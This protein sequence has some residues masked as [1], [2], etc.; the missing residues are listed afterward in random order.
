[1]PVSAKRPQADN[2]T[3]VQTEAL[4]L[5]E[6]GLAVVPCKDKRCLVPGWNERRLTRDEL[7]TALAVPGRNIAIALNLSGVIDLECDT[8]EAE[9]ALLKMFGGEVP[10]TP[11]WTSKRGKHRLFRRPEGLPEKAVAKVDGVE[12]RGLDTERGAISVVPPSTHPD[13]PTYAWLPG[14]S[15]YDVEPAELPPAVVERLRAPAAPPVATPAADGEI[16][17][18]QRND[19]LFRLAC[20][21]VADKLTPA[22][23][24]AALL[25][26]NAA[27][28]RPPL[29]AAEVREI[30]RSASAQ[31]EKGTGKA[32]A[33]ERLL[34]IAEAGAECWRTPGEVACATV[35]RDGHAEHYPLRSSAFRGWLARGFYAETGRA[36]GAQT[37]TDVVNVLEGRAR[38]DGAT[39]P[40]YVRV[41]G[42]EGR[43]YLDLADGEWRAVRVDGK[44]WRVVG[45]PPVRFRRPKGMLPLPAPEPGGSAADLRA[46]LNVGEEHWPLVLAWLVAALR[47]SGPFPVL[48]LLGEQ[49]SA[50][51]TA[52]RVLRALVDP[53]SAPVRSAPRSDRDLMIAAN[54]GWVVC[55]DNL[56]WVEG[57]LSDGLCRLSTGGGFATR[58]LYEDDE[59]ALFD[60]Q[61]PAVLNGIE[62]VGFR[63]DLLDR[64][65][66]VEL[67]RIE[68]AGR[69][70]E[71]VFWREFEGARP[72][73]LGTLLT[74]VSAALRNLPAVEKRG[75]PWP[76]MADFAMWAVAA[77][78][79]LGLEP[80][81]FLAAYEA[82]RAEAGRAA[83]ES[84]PVVKALETLLNAPDARNGYEG[85]A[86]ALLAKL[87]WGQDTRAKA[88]PKSPRALSGL[89]NRLAPNLRAAGVDIEQ[90]DR[91]AGNDKRKVWRVKKADPDKAAP[92]PE[93][94]PE[95]L[96]EPERPPTREETRKEALAVVA[97]LKARGA[98]GVR[99]ASKEPRR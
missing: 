62:D 19:T 54:N 43:A 8:P 87:S 64:S 12:F 45:A 3:S 82:N 38:F 39:Y 30:A 34:A 60:A 98:G 14:L 22:A 72:R 85:T 25:E 23:V 24:E 61:R 5:E 75:G 89:L 4:R 33:A 94:E 58:K 99:G 49:G 65:L 90:A 16:P 69:K 46:F 10:P 56:S 73:I 50:K 27:R 36:A 68:P 92:E 31:A 6:R 44:G 42:H 67:P 81:A 32:P 66:I 77:E 59:E 15:F 76:R 55:L 7:K 63:S 78:P 93:P 21:L 86:T 96:P 18:G 13:G 97:R 91:G 28:C 79:A 74:A 35:R 1:M 84:S 47:P 48:K 53:N 11:T 51:T 71:A 95:R 29:P 37:L 2:G 80:G 41:A 52:A 70:P 20:R 83:L 88:W 40:L 26:E 9:A 57:D 17:E